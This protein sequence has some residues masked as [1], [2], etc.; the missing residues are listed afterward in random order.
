MK[1]VRGFLDF[2]NFYQSLIT[3]YGKIAGP[4]YA[5]T[6]KNTTFIWEQ[7]EE[8]MFIIFKKRVVKEPVIHDTDPE[9]PYEV[10]IDISN[11]AIG[12]QLEQRDNQNKLHLIA[13]FL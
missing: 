8:D 3:G 13:F 2:T 1:D 6:K 7:K 12:V 10:D 4:F 11:F 5:L 9:K